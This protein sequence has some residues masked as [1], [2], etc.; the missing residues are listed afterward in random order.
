MLGVTP[1]SAPAAVAHHR[2]APV[3]EYLPHPVQVPVTDNTANA[4][5]LLCLAHARSDCAAYDTLGTIAVVE[6]TIALICIFVNCPEVLRKI[7]K[8]SGKHTK[9]TLQV[10]TTYSGN[11]GHVHDCLGANPTSTDGNNGVYWARPSQCFG[12]N[13]TSALSES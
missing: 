7:T 10:E 3:I 2:H 4:L 13:Q 9:M 12:H 11:V 1:A 5:Y 6:G 8:G